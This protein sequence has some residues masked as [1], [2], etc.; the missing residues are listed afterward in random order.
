MLKL[1]PS[2]ADFTVC[3]VNDDM[4]VIA[5]SNGAS[6]VDCFGLL[7]EK[8]DCLVALAE[9]DLPFVIVT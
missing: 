5:A 6:V 2:L 9:L 4:S 7:V 8:L 1:I 3:T